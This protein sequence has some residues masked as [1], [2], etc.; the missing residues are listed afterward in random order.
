MM[1]FGTLLT[2]ALIPT[3]SFA[4]ESVSVAGP[5]EIKKELPPASRYEQLLATPGPIVISEKYSI[6]EIDPPKECCSF[7]FVARISYRE[8]TP[9]IRFFTLHEGNISIDF[10]KIPL[11]IKDLKSFS[12]R[13][14]AAEGNETAEVFYR[15]SHDYDLRYY[16]YRN[17]KGVLQQNLVL[18]FGN[19]TGQGERMKQRLASY[20][21]TMEAG[22]AKLV[23]L[24]RAK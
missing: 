12:E 13:M 4:Q 17:N 9:R 16:S 6:P 20:I 14:R 1:I 7:R 24:K 3:G 22:Y 2:I 5:V 18:H 23:E 8:S 21:S 19:Y 11:L 15:Y 10:E